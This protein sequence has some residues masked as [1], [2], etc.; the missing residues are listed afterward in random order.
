VGPRCWL[1]NV[2]RGGL[3]R[4]DDLVEAL[5]SGW[6]AGA[7]LDVVDPEPLPRDS[8]LWSIDNCLIT[9]HTANP[10]ETEAAA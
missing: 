6:I 7:A 9:P 1:V 2:A 3:V 4:T 8:N 10:R 5:R